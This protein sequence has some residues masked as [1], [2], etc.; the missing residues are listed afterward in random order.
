MTHIHSHL[1]Y[2]G[3]HR[4]RCDFEDAV[5]RRAAV[6]GVCLAEEG[7][8]CCW[9]LHS[10]WTASFFQPFSIPSAPSGPW[11]APGTTHHTLQSSWY[12][13]VREHSQVKKMVQ[14]WTIDLFSFVLLQCWLTNNVRKKKNHNLWIPRWVGLVCVTVL[15]WAVWTFCV[16]TT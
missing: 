1:D 9:V 15:K 12:F 10:F 14:S 13:W 16:N 5:K 8:L 6:W 7:T 4:S 11:T 3:E 2:G